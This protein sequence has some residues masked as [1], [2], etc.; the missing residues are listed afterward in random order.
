MVT[1][2]NVPDWC[3]RSASL[4][5]AGKVGAI[6]GAN[7]PANSSPCEVWPWI[8]DDSDVAKSSTVFPH[9]CPHAL[10]ALDVDRSHHVRQLHDRIHRRSSE[11]E[12]VEL[13]SDCDL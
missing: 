13:R 5:I 4:V 12:P 8:V 7:A 2:K 1:N 11:G 3:L 10:L 9:S 6:G